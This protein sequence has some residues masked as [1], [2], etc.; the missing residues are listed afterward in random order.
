MLVIKDDLSVEK[1][2]GTM[3]AIQANE[4]IIIVVVRA[5]RQKRTEGRGIAI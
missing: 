2:S 4:T 3:D 5:V 1:K